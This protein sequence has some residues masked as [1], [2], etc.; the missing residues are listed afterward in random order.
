MV[1]L[2]TC[3]SQR[4]S[5]NCQSCTANCIQFSRMFKNLVNLA[6]DWFSGL[7]LG[8][9]RECVGDT[10]V[11]KSGGT[12]VRQGWRCVCGVCRISTAFERSRIPVLRAPCPS[13]LVGCPLR[14][15]L[16]PA[17]EPGPAHLRTRLHGV[18]HPQNVEAVV[19]AL[20]PPSCLVSERSCERL[21]RGGSSPLVLV[22]SLQSACHSSFTDDMA[23]LPSM[24][25]SP[26]DSGVFLSVLLLRFRAGERVWRFAVRPLL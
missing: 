4:C 20:P 22:S 25:L 23:F 26:I 14:S 7:V 21:V 18:Q 5:F 12:A 1:S 2:L 3:L 15:A 17:R 13:P 24:C 8:V 6:E 11:V 16:R 9:L 19:G 10:A